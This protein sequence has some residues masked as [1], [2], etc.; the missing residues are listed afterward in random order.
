MKPSNIRNEAQSILAD[1]PHTF[2]ALANA[3]S[4]NARDHFIASLRDVHRWIATAFGEPRP[5]N[6]GVMQIADDLTRWITVWVWHPHAEWW[7]AQLR[8][9]NHIGQERAA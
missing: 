6:I 9:I 5:A 1:I 3:D 4:H 7:V 2:I 8:H